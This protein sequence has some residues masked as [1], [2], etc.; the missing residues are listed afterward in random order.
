MSY[1]V[2]VILGNDNISLN[3]IFIKI[4]LKEIKNRGIL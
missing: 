2:N 3:D 4:L 1:K